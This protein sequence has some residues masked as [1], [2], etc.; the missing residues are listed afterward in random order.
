MPDMLVRLHALP[1]IVPVLADLK[2]KGIEVRQGHPSEK[3][4]ITGWVR[5]H[6]KESW[7]VGCEVGLGQRPVG[8]YIAIQRDRQHVPSVNPYDLPDECLLGFACYDV[9]SKGVFGPMGVREDARGQ[10]IGTALLLTCLHAMA[11][12]RYAY[13]AIGQVGPADFYAKTV[14]ATVIEDSEP[15]VA[16]RPLRG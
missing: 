13:A 7:A 1:G 10:G 15:G 5:E 2:N 11:S 6:F 14:G 3:Y 16:R 12:E 9:A 8:C 4:I